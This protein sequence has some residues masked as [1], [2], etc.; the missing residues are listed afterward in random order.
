MSRATRRLKLDAKDEKTLLI[1]E[2]T[3]TAKPVRGRSP[4]SLALA[5]AIGAC[6]AGMNTMY[7]QASPTAHARLAQL[8][9]VGIYPDRRNG[10]FPCRVRISRL[11]R[12]RHRLSC[13]P[14]DETAVATGH[15]QLRFAQR[16]FFYFTVTPRVNV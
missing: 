7:G 9:I 6:F 1:T 11:A 12:G 4:H 14:A 5:M 13:G 3:T 2:Q 8:R 16:T 10:Q 15:H